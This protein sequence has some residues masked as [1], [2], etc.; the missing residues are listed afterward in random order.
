VVVGGGRDSAALMPDKR[1][2]SGTDPE[3]GRPTDPATCE[4]GR[5][6]RSAA[7]ER[8]QESTPTGCGW[9]DGAERAWM[10]TSDVGP[11]T[12]AAA[13]PGRGGVERR[14]DAG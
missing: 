12:C 6:R 3:V 8:L 10:S 7:R 5:P 2:W 14:H 1:C 13:D 11:A 4:A 9:A